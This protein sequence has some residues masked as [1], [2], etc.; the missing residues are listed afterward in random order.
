MAACGGGVVGVRKVLSV[1]GGE[2]LVHEGRGNYLLVHTEE[3]RRHLT[4]WGVLMVGA[5]CANL[6]CVV[7]RRGQMDKARSG[8]AEVG[9]RRTTFSV[10]EKMKR[11]GEEE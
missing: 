4:S 9:G 5:F 6:C 7:V 2:E 10:L 1:C 11:M 3:R 8:E